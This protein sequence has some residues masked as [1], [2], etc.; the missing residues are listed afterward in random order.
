M[1]WSSW[2]ESVSRWLG[3][4]LQSKKF[5]KK[6]ND[7][8]VRKTHKLIF[9]NRYF[10]PFLVFSFYLQIF[11]IELLF[12]FDIFST[13]VFAF[14]LFTIFRWT[15][16]AQDMDIEKKNRF[17]YPKAN[18]K[19]HTLSSTKTKSKSTHFR[20]VSSISRFS[21]FCGNWR[22]NT[23]L[24]KHSKDLRTYTCRH[25]SMCICLYVVLTYIYV[26]ISFAGMCVLQNRKFY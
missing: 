9:S 2:S 17:I 24:N 4:C 20:Y 26:C 13:F 25:C 8:D 5:K 18:R 19:N 6:S 15:H 23:L 12:F 1:R 16:T 11:V 7:I 14:N 22:A 3:A 10:F 21:V